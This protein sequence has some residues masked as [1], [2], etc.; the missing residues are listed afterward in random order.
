MPGRFFAI[1][2]LVLGIPA[3]RSSHSFCEH[4]ALDDLVRGLAAVHFESRK[5]LSAFWAV[6]IAVGMVFGNAIYHALHQP[7]APAFAVFVQQ[8]LAFRATDRNG[9]NVFACHE[10]IER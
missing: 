9:P 2:V 1:A 8:A 6:H 4:F 3:V 5:C 7:P 10:K